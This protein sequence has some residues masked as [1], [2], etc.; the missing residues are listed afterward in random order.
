MRFPP[1]L[2][3]EIRA[4]LPVTS[5]VGKRVR[6]QK[7][8]RE[9]KGLSPFNAEK[10]P[11][12]YVNDQKGFYHCFSSGQHGD[13]FKFLMTT[14]GLSFPDAVERLAAEAGVPL[15]KMTPE[16]E[17]LI[18]QR[19]DLYD[20]M[21][22]ACRFFEGQLQ[23]ASGAHARAYLQNRVI[24][25]DM[26]AEFRLG[27]APDSRTALLDYLRSQGVSDDLILRSGLIIEPDEGRTFYDRFRGRVIFPIQDMKGRVVAFGGRA[28]DN[29]RG[30][31]YLNSPETEMF[32]KGRLVF[33]GHRAR[34]AAFK[35]SN[36]IV[37]EG[38][39]DAIA[40]FQAGVK[41]VVATLGTA[42]T[43]AQI[44][45]LW[46]LAPEPIL[47]FDG[48]RAGQ[49]AAFRALDRMLPF[50][51]IGRSFRFA[52]LPEGRDPDDLIKQ[53][54]LEG[55]RKVTEAAHK[56]WDVLWDREIQGVDAVNPDSM[57]KLDAKLRGLVGQISDPQL[58][59]RYEL[60]A[61]IHIKDFFWKATRKGF[62]DA[63]GEVSALSL[64][65]T[66]ELFSGEP[67]RMVGWERLFLGLCV[68][69]PDFAAQACDE[70]ARV[71]FRGTLKLHSGGVQSFSTFAS[72][73]LDLIEEEGIQ[74]S[75][76]IY[77][78]INPV[79]FDML[80]FL[81]GRENEHLPAGYRLRERFPILNY[82]VGEEYLSR[83]FW[84][85]LDMLVQR[86]ME[87]ELATELESLS[88][89]IDE[90]TSRRLTG[91]KA[92]ILER[93]DR[94]LTRDSELAEEGSAWRAALRPALQLAA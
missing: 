40:A 60:S 35:S 67:T 91:Y 45:S 88:D 82:H 39:M 74:D 63:K 42:F 86:E 70:I 78:R 58:R 20:V 89:E 11:S 6:L 73:L 81:H 48:D 36:V 21:E 25:P 56:F 44:Q 76:S 90:Q 19:R 22:V 9:W 83:C 31:K 62:A 34:E 1:A 68:E 33:N 38:Y 14:E 29:E 3:E 64:L 8:G 53:S 54:G 18:E 79:F 51:R 52:F 47:C 59:Y 10:T 87:D 23:K 37:V 92:E 69:Y 55:F 50:I 5:V 2:L 32:E 65:R 17:R 71:T 28:L 84:H 24:A 72:C 15:P 7:A 30:P 46:Q 66:S 4:R 27:Y 85:F 61:R 75:R 41:A 93:R 43:E 26:Q 57:A 16:V 80:D 94:I 13:I 77:R 49:A 12:F